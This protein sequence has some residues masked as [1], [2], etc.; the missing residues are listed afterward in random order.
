MPSLNYFSAAFTLVLATGLHPVPLRAQSLPLRHFSVH[1]GLIAGEVNTMFQDSRGFLWIGTGEGLSRFDGSTFTNYAVTN[2]LPNP[3]VNCI[4]ESHDE[5]GSLLIGTQGGGITRAVPQDGT[6]PLHFSSVWADSALFTRRVRRIIQDPSGNLWAATVA[7]IYRIEHGRGIPFPGS[8]AETESDIALS[9]DGTIIIG[10][11][12]VLY[13]VHPQ[14]LEYDTLAVPIP[15]DDSILLLHADRSGR[16]WIATRANR[17]LTF[18]DG[19]FGTSVTLTTTRIDQILTDTRDNLWLCTR[20]GLYSIPVRE[21]GSGLFTRYSSEN[22]LQGDFTPCALFDREQDLW[23]GNN[24][25]GISRWSRMDLGIFHVS[26][27]KQIHNNSAVVVDRAGHFWVSATDGLHEIR[28]KGREWIH[29]IHFPLGPAVKL[30]PVL[31]FDTRG[32]LWVKSSHGLIRRFEIRHGSGASSLVPSAAI[33]LSAKFPGETG[34]C[35]IVDRRGFLWVS[36]SALGVAVFDLS[37]PSPLLT[38][39]YTEADGFTARSAR[40]LYEDR[41]GRIWMAGFQGGI[42]IAEDGPHGPLTGPPGVLRNLPEGGVR[43]IREDREGNMVFGTRYGGLVVYRGDTLQTITAADGLISNAVWCVAAD[44]LGNLWL[45][46]QRGLQVLAGGERPVVPGGEFTGS[47]VQTCGVDSPMV[48][49]ATADAFM[50]FAPEATRPDPIPPPVYL[51]SFEVNSN[52]V[53]FMESLR[54]DYDENNC[55]VEFLGLSLRNEQGI[56]YRYRLVGADDLWHGPVEK[57]SVSYAALRPGD[58]R[59]EVVAVNGTDSESRVPAQLSFTIREP[60]WETW[61]F[62]LLVLLMIP[63][64]IG[65]F[66]LRRLNVVRREAVVRQGFTRQLLDAQDA[67]RRRIA[68]EL[69]DGLGQS[70]I[71]MQHGIQHAMLTTTSGNSEEL[72]R[73]STVASDAMNEVR[74]IS[75]RLHPAALDQLGLVKAVSSIAGKASRLAQLSIACEIGALAGIV[76][77]DREIHV[78]RIVQEAFNN[79]LKHSGA[80]E[81]SVTAE[82]TGHEV[83]LTI[84]DNGT[85][86]SR[87]PGNGTSAQLGLNGMT[88]R[89]R[90]V[91]GL[92]ELQTSPGGGTSVILHIPISHYEPVI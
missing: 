9:A 29:D 59:F 32:A 2:G 91:G 37:G 72:R 3:Y 64:A 25:K 69:H 27:E 84:R 30:D 89:A 8:N 50:L 90:M 79:I 10:T 57:N 19:E 68:G 87:N 76:P 20:T 75:S 40:V 82:R 73:I 28:K 49:F 24:R 67:E 48:W 34:L 55:S 62:Q 42:S 22:G 74:E 26:F 70:L 4:A 1:D 78:Y 12:R 77:R 39:V 80:T 17:I 53:S 14:N 56:R 31:A 54:L 65:W 23:I 92:L 85:G 51:T 13:R 41:K 16:L 58:Y 5:P 60:F 83:V 43:S 71:L 61:W 7:G 46:T 35:F 86:F 47:P 81:A 21:F 33:D 63:L 11:N 44:Q 88:E 38:R 45:G 66:F 15:P 6:G 52:P 36:L 18:G